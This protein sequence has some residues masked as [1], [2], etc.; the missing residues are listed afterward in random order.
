[1]MTKG[2][3][4]VGFTTLLSFWGLSFLVDT[5]LG[6]LNNLFVQTCPHMYHML[7]VV[8]STYSTQDAHHSNEGHHLQVIHD[9]TWAPCHESYP[10]QH[11]RIQMNEHLNTTNKNTFK[12]EREKK[13]IV[14]RQ[15]N[16][17]HSYMENKKNNPANHYLIMVYY[18]QSM[19]GDD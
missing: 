19:N 8:S 6:D 10:I 13:H 18:K 1:M 5:L 12:S 11:I 14:L 2:W 17:P 15:Y 16:H 7:A 9:V 3:C 4:I